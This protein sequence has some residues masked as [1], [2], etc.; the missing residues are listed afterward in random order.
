MARSL[1]QVLAELE[2]SYSGSRSLYQTQ[3]DAIPSEVDAGIAQADAKLEQAHESILAGARR[4]NLGYAGIPMGEQAKYNATE[5]APAIA[6][7]KSQGQQRK[8]SI[9]EA[10]QGLDRDKRTSGQSIYD[11]ELSRDFQERQFQEQIRQFS[12]SQKAAAR[13]AAAA[14]SGGYGFGG[15]GGGAAPA[16]SGG[17]AQMAYSPK[18]G[19]QFVDG[20]GRPI[21]AAM[22]ANAKGI[23]Y[24]DLLSQMATQGD[25]NASIALHLVGDDFKADPRK[26]ANGF[27]TKTMSYG[28]NNSNV[29]AALR[30]L[31]VVNA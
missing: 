30:A 11:Q 5:Y 7:M 26:L 1:D 13:A 28:A 6:N 14:S 24:R 29:R 9:L 20:N 18:S 2:P 17:S 19:F 3:L 25:K 23:N 12:E 16:G 22:Y 8:M 21:N 27:D 31:G 10:L 4:R 15:G